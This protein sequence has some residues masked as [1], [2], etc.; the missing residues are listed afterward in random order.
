LQNRGHRSDPVRHFA[1]DLLRLGDCS[2]LEVRYDPRRALLEELRQARPSLISMPISDQVPDRVRELLLALE[3][4]QQA[5][6][7]PRSVVRTRRRIF[8]TED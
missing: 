5:I 3:T 2:L 4:P 1:L 7:D 8:F 6:P